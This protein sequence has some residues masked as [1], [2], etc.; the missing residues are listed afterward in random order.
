MITRKA[1]PNGDECKC[2]DEQAC[3]VF[4]AVPFVDDRSGQEQL[5]LGTAIVFTWS[6][7]VD[8]GDEELPLTAAALRRR[9]AEVRRPPGRTIHLPGHDTWPRVPSRVWH[10][11]PQPMRLRLHGGLARARLVASV[12]C[13]RAPQRV[14]TMEQREE[15]RLAV[16]GDPGPR[17]PPRASSGGPLGRVRGRRPGAR[18]RPRRWGG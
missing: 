18:N 10:L 13:S 8:L 7:H 16:R 11:R 5:R 14:V 3:P 15:D 17:R 4:M 2:F 9:V 12:S 6:S 1:R